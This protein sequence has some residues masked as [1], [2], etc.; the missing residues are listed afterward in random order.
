MRVSPVGWVCSS[1]DETLELA[2]HSAAPTHDHP[3]GIKGAQA[4]AGAVFLARSGAS[5]EEIRSQVETLFGYDLGRTLAEIRPVYAF[6]P[7]CQGSVPEAL[8]AFL[9]SNG[10]EDA[11]RKA[12]SLGGDSD[13]QACIAG[14]V[15]EAFYGGAPFDLVERVR[16][17][18]PGEMTRILDRFGEVFPNRP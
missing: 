13:T 7:T 12:V 6:D 8:T 11:L 5:K 15:A 4:V 14:A 2:R 18:L 17:L 1:L 10:F 9:E 16:A 3:E